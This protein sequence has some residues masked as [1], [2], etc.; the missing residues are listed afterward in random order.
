MH[1]GVG[2]YAKEFLS[3]EIILQPGLD[4]RCVLQ[5]EQ[6]SEE[7]QTKNFAARVGMDPHGHQR[8]SSQREKRADCSQTNI[9][10]CSR[11]IRLKLRKIW[12]FIFRRVRAWAILSPKVKFGEMAYGDTILF[13]NVNSLNPGSERSSELFVPTALAKRLCSIGCSRGQAA[14]NSGNIEDG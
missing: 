14:A 9:S 13:E 11:K 12:K 7:S 2:P 1:S 5:N 8:P 3:K 4:Q 10:S 6:K